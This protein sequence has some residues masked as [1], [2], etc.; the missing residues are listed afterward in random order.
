MAG[1]LDVVPVADDLV[2]FVL[3]VGCVGRRRRRGEDVN[4]HAD[5]DDD[6][7]PAYVV[8]DRSG[9][10]VLMHGGIVVTVEADP[11][12]VES[13]LAAGKVECPGCL[14]VLRPWGW[15]RPRGV[16]GMDGVLRPRRTRCAGCLVTHVLLP[17]TL[18]LRRAYAAEVIGAA[19]LARAT[20]RGPV[21]P[22]RFPINRR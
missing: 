16:H 9:R 4:N 12:R 13:R 15:A 18:L 21:T 1:R 19:L 6:G 20:G 2:I 7:P 3:S 11:V 8:V 10:A 5:E 14:G 17:V 22:A